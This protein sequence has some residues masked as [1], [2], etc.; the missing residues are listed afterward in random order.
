[1]LQTFQLS[2]QQQKTLM[3]MCEDLA[4]HPGF[5]SVKELDQRTG[6]PEAGL[7]LLSSHYRRT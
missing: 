2:A 7:K 1:M 3:G 6:D 4:E 5:K